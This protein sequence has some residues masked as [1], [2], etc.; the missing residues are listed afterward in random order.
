[1][2]GL[3]VVYPAEKERIPCS[4]WEAFSMFFMSHCIFSDWR[5]VSE[6]KLF[7]S[8][9]ESPPSDK[10]SVYMTILESGVLS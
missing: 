6:R 1:M 5:R 2:V 7:C 10:S 4:S 8:S 9:V 3:I